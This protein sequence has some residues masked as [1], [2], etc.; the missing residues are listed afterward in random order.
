[1][2]KGD[3]ISRYESYDMFSVSSTPRRTDEKLANPT[4]NIKDTV[5][6]SQ[7]KTDRL[8]PPKVAPS[9]NR[10]AKDSQVE[11]GR[12]GRFVFMAICLPPYFVL[13]GI[14]KWIMVNLLPN[15]MKV[16]MQGMK[17]TGSLA[18]NLKAWV[19]E[20]IVNPLRDAFGKL[21]F[22]I[23]E[24]GKSAGEFLSY[25]K[26]GLL[27]PF[28]LMK[29]AALYPLKMAGELVQETSKRFQE[30]V[31]L[32]HL[33]FK[34]I[35]EGL[36]ELGNSFKVARKVVEAPLIKTREALSVLASAFTEAFAKAAKYKPEFSFKIATSPESP[37]KKIKSY[38]EKVGNAVAE[39]RQMVT[40]AVAA[41][42]Q[43][44]INLLIELKS[45]PV[46]FSK[47]ALRRLREKSGQAIKGVVSKVRSALGQGKRFFRSLPG[48]AKSRVQKVVCF[49]R[50]PVRSFIREEI[51]F[52]AD[53]YNYIHR[54]IAK[55]LAML[56]FLYKHLERAVLK[57]AAYIQ[58]QY[59]RAKRL[60]YAAKGAMIA[61][62]F[63]FR[64]LFRNFLKKGAAAF[65]SL[66]RGTASVLRAFGSLFKELHSE[67]RSWIG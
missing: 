30:V 54:I 46:E 38:A 51:P 41:V 50:G 19:A 7:E 43:P 11:V 40:H 1:M 9:D 24:L 27:K 56:H 23:K 49:F 39:A 34:R 47:A 14:P 62:E 26:Q 16:S 3:T 61:A 18:E 5:E 8:A 13:Y 32:T 45:E 63:K 33:L 44:V 55:V 29:A 2:P 28:H 52:L 36:K 25:L 66:I 20:A 12:A 17:F 65:V 10:A 37:F 48:R 35:N 60:A 21:Q 42:A 15:V 59:I 31:K 4:K 58:K 57:K 53:A 64:R 6:T 67:V 22:V